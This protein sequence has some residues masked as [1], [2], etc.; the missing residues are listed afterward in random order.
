MCLFSFNLGIRRCEYVCLKVLQIYIHF[1]EE[2]HAHVVDKKIESQKESIWIKRKMK[3]L[4]LD[5]LGANNP[6]A[7]KDAKCFLDHLNVAKKWNPVD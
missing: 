5:V 6:H 3:N 4:G 2:E 1:Q 7:K